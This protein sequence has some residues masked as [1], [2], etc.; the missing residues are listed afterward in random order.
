MKTVISIL[1][2]FFITLSV[3]FAVFT[4]KMKENEKDKNI[5]INGM[6][7]TE[8][9][10][11]VHI[12]SEMS[13]ERISDELRLK[14]DIMLDGIILRM[15]L[16]N[17]VP[18][19]EDIYIRNLTRASVSLKKSWLEFP[20]IKVTLEGIGFVDSLCTIQKDCPQGK[21]KSIKP[22]FGKPL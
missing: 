18:Q 8:F 10:Q 9:I 19:L 7:A 3:C 4:N 16:H 6:L 20:P 1:T 5:Y 13:D 21:V 17:S 22:D 12:R 15:E 14:V 11:L 2:V